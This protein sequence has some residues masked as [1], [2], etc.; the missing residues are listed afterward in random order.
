MADR[1]F[2]DDKPPAVAL[3]RRAPRRRPP[4][5]RTDLDVFARVDS[6][7]DRNRSP[8]A[9]IPGLLFRTFEAKPSFIP[10]GSMAPRA[11]PKQGLLVS[12]VRLNHSQ[13]ARQQRGRA[14]REQRGVVGGSRS[15]AVTC[16][17]CRLPG[18]RR[19][20]HGRRGASTRRMA[21]IDF[22]SN[23]FTYE[24]A[25]PELW[26]PCPCSSIPAAHKPITPSACVVCL[27]E[28]LRIRTR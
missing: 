15:V 22:V 13:A 27:N 7:D 11:G 23:K 18:Q 16:P 10:T 1:S 9:F 12:Q 6:R 24:F 19:S 20:A 21:A 2:A 5:R 17:L 4:R 3:W 8:V 26:G 28:T 14:T 25:Q